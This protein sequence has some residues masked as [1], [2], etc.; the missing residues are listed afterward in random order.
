[1]K[2]LQICPGAYQ[3]GR[4]GISE[5][6]KNI[7]ERL[8]NTHDVTVYAT[9]PL[10]KLPWAEFVSG[11]KVRRFRRF[12]PSGSY[13][14]S[15]NMIMNLRK[16]S[17]D[18]VHAHAY[19]A[20]PMHF[21]P[22]T[23]HQKLFF[24]THFH[25]AGHTAIRDCFFHL[26]K[27]IGKS[28]LRKADKIIAVSE[29]EKRLLCSTFAID[30][31]DVVVVPN[32]LD[33]SAFKG[34]KRVKSVG[35]SI[36]YVGRLESY[37]GVQYLIDVLP[38]LENDVALQIVGN[39]SMRRLLEDQIRRF[40]LQDRVRFFQNLSREELLQKYVDADVL[41][42]L[43]THE[44]YSMVV[45]E[46]LAA[47]TP[48]VVADTSALSEWIDNDM[49]FGVKSPVV[50]EELSVTLSRVMKEDRK[51]SARDRVGKKILDWCDTVHMLEDLY[52]T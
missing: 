38:T 5:H 1:M 22:L 15:P 36:L 21:S 18:V 4:G 14:F 40:R 20:F 50:L 44:A 48:C 39:G 33:L 52:A 3:S 35:R 13:F 16:E 2:I 51:R 34:L 42:L 37:K 29:F 10:G 17:Y 25:N 19:H 47:G 30:S 28:T 9:N 8:A 26:F 7:S 32:G 24:T 31:D 23:R 45:A 6:I 41:V 27:P 11:V 43:S 49:C 46:A 12:A